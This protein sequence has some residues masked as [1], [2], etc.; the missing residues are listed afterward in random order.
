MSSTDGVKCGNVMSAV[1]QTRFPYFFVTQCKTFTVFRFETCMVGFVSELVPS[2]EH[3]TVFALFVYFHPSGYLFAT[4]CE[5]ILRF[6][7]YKCCEI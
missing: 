7:S 4:F 3:F 1:E 6:A 2:K 5:I